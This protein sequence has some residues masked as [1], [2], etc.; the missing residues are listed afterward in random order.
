MRKER[1]KA[2]ALTVEVAKGGCV[3]RSDDGE[4]PRNLLA[5]GLFGEET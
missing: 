2:K 5:M 3:V 4:A 1:T